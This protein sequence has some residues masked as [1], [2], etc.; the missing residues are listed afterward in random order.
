MNS[1]Q[2]LLANKC[3]VQKADSL[4]INKSKP[5]R[6]IYGETYDEYGM[7]IDSLKYYLFLSLLH[8]TLEGMGVEVKSFVVI[9]NL[10]S[11]KNKIVQ[12]KDG[13]L[14]EANARLDQIN[15]IKSIFKLK[16]EPVLMSDIFDSP[17]FKKRLETIM[18][19][20]NEELKELAKKTV[21]QNRQSQEEKSGFSYVLEEVALIMDFDI[22]IG[23]PREI[24]FDQ[25]AQKL[26]SDLRGIYL[27][28]TYPL[29]M[30]FDFFINNPEIEEFGL[31]PYKAGS[32]KMQDHRIILGKTSDKDIKNLIINSFVPRDMFLANPILDLACI[33]GMRYQIDILD[34]LNNREELTNRLL[35]LIKEIV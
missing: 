26:G 21:L 11:I 15:K 28:P 33:V 20:F 17:E 5:I 29:G 4:V 9:G 7:T 14:A 6:I 12:N 24:Y 18:P 13:L 25:L 19:I 34:L 16:F 30:D 2:K 1:L 10:H 27:R 32:N 3:L 8:K 23:P 22:K 31:T 35:S